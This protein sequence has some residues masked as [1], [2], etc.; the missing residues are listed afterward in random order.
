MKVKCLKIISAT[1]HEDLGKD[2]PWLTIGKEY[3]V[4][5]IAVTPRGGISIYFQSDDRNE[6]IFSTLLGFEVTSNYLPSN[7][8][9]K[10]N[11]HN[12]YYMMPASWMYDSFLED[13]EDQEEKAMQLFEAE[14]RVIY[15]EENKL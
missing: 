14:A 3:T 2:S 5:S 12:E 10:F 8:S 1:T 6:P 9:V 15:E 13:L 11:K 4:L 7:W